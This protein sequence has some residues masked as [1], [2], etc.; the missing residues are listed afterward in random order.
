[1]TDERILEL[2]K[3]W[4]RHCMADTEMVSPS[5]ELYVEL[6]QEAILGFAHAVMHESFREEELAK[7]SQRQ[8]GD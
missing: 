8:V 1:M 5:G 6:C 7:L 4:G 3:E 2:A